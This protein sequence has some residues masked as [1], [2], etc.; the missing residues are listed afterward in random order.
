MEPDVTPTPPPFGS[1]PS[2]PAPASALGADEDR[3]DWQ[4]E[5]ADLTSPKQL[6]GS[7]FAGFSRLLLL[8]TKQG[9]L[10]KAGS[11]LLLLFGLLA[12]AADFLAP[13]S[14]TQL[15]PSS[16]IHGPIWTES[17]SLHHFFG[18]DSIGR[19]LLSRLIYGGRLTL[20]IAA[21]SALISVSIGVGLGLGAGFL[22]HSH[23]R[24]A[25]A[26]L[27]RIIDCAL[28]VP[29]LAAAAAVAG[30]WH[31]SLILAM[32][33]AS[34][35]AMAPIARLIRAQVITLGSQQS[36]RDYD[37][38]LARLRQP[39][40]RWQQI[41]DTLHHCFPMIRLL[42]VFAL[43]DA[44]LTIAALGF[45]GLGAA[46]PAAEWGTMVADGRLLWSSHPW[47][48]LAP[49]LCIGLVIMSCHCVV[50]S[51]RPNLAPNLRERL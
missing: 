4:Q 27:T 10:A 47:L 29:P 49:A 51:I 6:A 39:I 41:K 22:A 30:A 18:T 36:R 1:S 24:K 37:P 5:H 48:S 3:Y 14:P 23:H 40:D 15:Y 33:V 21:L 19:D 43:S 20:G 44:I 17:G 46:P 35:F 32:I 25:A 28:A 42:S 11:R 45:F 2:A 13:Y 12:L 8:F 50:G 26:L 16:V 9:R 31:S 7:W 38:S 34:V